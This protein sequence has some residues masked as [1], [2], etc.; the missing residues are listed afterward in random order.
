VQERRLELDDAQLAFAA[1]A[2]LDGRQP[3][4]GVE[5]LAEL[6]EAMGLRNGERL[7]LDWLKRRDGGMSEANRT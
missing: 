7:L 6:T 4:A 1:L 3:R 2:A 5:A